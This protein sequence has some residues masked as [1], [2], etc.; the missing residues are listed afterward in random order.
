ME[1]PIKYR[2]YP[3]S[4]TGTLEREDSITEECKG[5]GQEAMKSDE[6]NFAVR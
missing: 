5:R 2:I 3:S 6:N 4:R 1:K